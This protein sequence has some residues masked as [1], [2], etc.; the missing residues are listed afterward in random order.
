[1]NDI[2]QMGD[3]ATPGDWNRYSFYVH[4]GNSGEVMNV[5]ITVTPLS[6]DPDL[7]VRNNATGAYYHW[8]SMGSFTTETITIPD[9][10][11]CSICRYSIVVMSLNH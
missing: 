2:G 9:N 4:N 8:K 6:G 3:V 1:M 11:R 10:D 7:G 5:T